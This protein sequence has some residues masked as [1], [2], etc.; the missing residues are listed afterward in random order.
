MK[1]KRILPWI[2]PIILIGSW[3][4][5]SSL[6]ILSSR[7]L[8]N[9]I[10]IFTAASGISKEWTIRLS[11]VDKHKKSILGIHSRWRDRFY[12]RFSEWSFENIGIFIR[13]FHSNDSKYSA[14]GINTDCHS[15][16]WNRRGS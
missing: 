13:L 11:C 6:G 8:P 10:D 16:V 4:L 9:P 1:S 12:F 5:F 3:Q 7:V 2:I 14:F 15:L